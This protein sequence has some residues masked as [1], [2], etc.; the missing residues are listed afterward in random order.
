MEKNIVPISLNLASGL[1][2]INIRTFIGMVG[3]SECN[4]HL[5]LAKIFNQYAGNLYYMKIKNANQVLT[6]LVLRSVSHVIKIK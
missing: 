5:A 3:L 2:V 1:L 4:F 6:D